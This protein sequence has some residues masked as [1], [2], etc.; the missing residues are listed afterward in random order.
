MVHLLPEGR[1]S[2]SEVAPRRPWSAADQLGAFGDRVSVTDVEGEHGPLPRREQIERSIEVDE[3]TAQL[4]LLPGSHVDQEAI[5]ERHRPVE[6]LPPAD[7]LIDADTCQSASWTVRV[8]NLRPCFPGREQRLLDGILSGRR[9]AGDDQ[10]EA[11]EPRAL[12]QDGHLES[13]IQLN[14]AEPDRRSLPIHDSWIETANRRFSYAPPIPTI[15]VGRRFGN[16]SV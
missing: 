2:A 13:A 1:D 12:G 11:V 10:G 16:A 15:Q 9:L 14:P 8:A 6:A 4:D 7:A 3:F 5:V